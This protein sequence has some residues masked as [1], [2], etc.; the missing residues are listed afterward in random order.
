[1]TD[2]FGGSNKDTVWKK[3]GSGQLQSWVDDQEKV[4]GDQQRCD[5]AEKFA[6][7]TV[8]RQHYLMVNLTATVDKNGGEV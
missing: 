2:G 1:M 8:K 7:K 6:F 4:S 3:F 5:A